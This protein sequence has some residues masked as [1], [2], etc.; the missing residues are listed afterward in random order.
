MST[1]EYQVPGGAPRLGVDLAGS[2]LPAVVHIQPGDYS[3][4]YV[5]PEGA[6]LPCAPSGMEVP[7]TSTSVN[8]ESELMQQFVAD[9]RAA[10]PR[11]QIYSSSSYAWGFLRCLLGVDGGGDITPTLFVD[12][13]RLPDGTYKVDR[14]KGTTV[15][16]ARDK[17]LDSYRASRSRLTRIILAIHPDAPQSKVTP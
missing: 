6:Q 12:V 11:R 7:V 8:E 17:A 2:A 3:A 1:P 5:I 16:E 4:P 14:C 10:F 15:V 9:V 13:C